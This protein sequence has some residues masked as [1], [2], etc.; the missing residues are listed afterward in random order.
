MDNINNI[1]WGLATFFSEDHFYLFIIKSATKSFSALNQIWRLWIIDM[2]FFAHK[3]LKKTTFKSCSEI[4][5]SSFF[6]LQP[7]QL[8]R[9]KQKNSCYRPTA[10]RTG[11]L[12]SFQIL[13]GG[14]NNFLF[15]LFGYSTN[16]KFPGSN[17]QFWNYKSEFSPN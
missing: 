7:A 11:I 16:I 4:L 13:T 14:F 10:Y 8:K 1:V 9:P 6:S 12:A 17:N 5:K 15:N 3:K 2:I